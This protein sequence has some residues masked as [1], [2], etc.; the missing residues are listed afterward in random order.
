MICYNEENKSHLCTHNPGEVLQH[1]VESPELLVVDR[2]HSSLE[3][4]VAV[5]EE[6]NLL[7]LAT[8]RHLD[9]R[10]AVREWRATAVGRHGVVPPHH[11]RRRR[12][13]RAVRYAHFFYLC[14]GGAVL[15]AVVRSFERRGHCGRG[16]G[17]MLTA[18]VAA[19]KRAGRAPHRVAHAHHKGFRQSVAQR[20]GHLAGA[21]VPQ[22]IKSLCKIVIFCLNKMR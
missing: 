20:L 13:Q 21:Q 22:R 15:T 11:N 1:F 8:A 19:G 6:A 5:D 2:Y 7:G 14:T 16:R 12:P 18:E 9:E 4:L 17:I 3:E 10:G